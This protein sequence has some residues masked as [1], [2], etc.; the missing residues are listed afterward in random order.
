MSEALSRIKLGRTQP[1]NPNRLHVRAVCVCPTCAKG[2]CRVDTHENIE[3]VCA[4]VERA[5]ER[6][7][8]KCLLL[9]FLRDVAACLRYALTRAEQMNVFAHAASTKLDARRPHRRTLALPPL[10]RYIVA[11]APKYPTTRRTLLWLSRGPKRF[12]Q[13]AETYQHLCR[14]N[15]KHTQTPH[16]H[17]FSHGDNT[18]RVCLPKFGGAPDSIPHIHWCCGTS[19][20]FC[21]RTSWRVCAKLSSCADIFGMLGK[22]H[23]LTVYRT[24]IPWNAIEIGV[25]SCSRCFPDIW[26][27]KSCD[28]IK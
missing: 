10:G 11:T 24:T 7:I 6:W 23:M 1:E 18:F 9:K 14:Q 17:A 2:C 22:A 27:V 5:H 13:R 28:P 20:G 12:W 16:K 15:C 21:V 8:E 25:D 19:L 4:G 3:Y 26:I